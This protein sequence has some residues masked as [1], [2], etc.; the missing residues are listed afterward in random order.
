MHA[1]VSKWD[2]RADCMLQVSLGPQNGTPNFRK[3]SYVHVLQQFA[4]SGPGLNRGQQE[5]V[6]YQACSRVV[7]PPPLT[8]GGGRF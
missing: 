6:S 8:Q 1:R 7:V 3:P 2:F 5:R 4:R